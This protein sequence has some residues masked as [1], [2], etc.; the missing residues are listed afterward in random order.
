MK[1]LFLSDSYPPEMT[2]H[3][4][5]TAELSHCWAKEGYDVNVLTSNPN[6]PRGELFE[7]YKNAWCEHTLEDKVKLIRIKT[8][9][10]P[11]K[12]FFKR[13]VD[14]LSYGINS[15]FIGLFQKK[16][17]IVIGLS[18]QFFCAV[19]ACFLALI[20]R[21]PFV[22]ILCDLWP[23]AV[24]SVGVMKQGILIKL[25]KKL[26]VFMYK[27]ASLII[28][29]SP[30][31]NTYLESLGIDKTKIHLSLSG[32]NDRVF[33]LMEKSEDL[34]QQ[35]NLHNKFVYSY[36]GTFGAAQNHEDI[37]NIAKT[38]KE[39]NKLDMHFLLLGEGVNKSKIEA[40]VAND[41]INNVI[42]DGPVPGENV[43]DYWSVSDVALVLL[44]DIDTNKTVIP[45]KMIEAMAMGKPI[46]LYA[47]KGEAQTLIEKTKTGWYIPVGNFSALQE[48]MIEV[49]ENPELLREAAQNAIEFSKEN[50]R[51]LQAERIATRLE[52]LAK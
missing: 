12:G 5:I 24:V 38:F 43:P 47:P 49:K 11:N 22:F 1:I 46:L 26:E 14:F 17:D 32:A 52:T 36:I 42:V 50:T 18:P 30:Y 16:V 4:R 21:K 10:S 20:K 6:F 31:F 28:T 51:E 44:K 7:G 13:I 33:Y 37:I 8:F 45:S 2:A 40:L 35:Y 23:D 3:G 15:F 27:R 19:S 34:C 39:K 25:V 48:K 9:M 29:L 41:V